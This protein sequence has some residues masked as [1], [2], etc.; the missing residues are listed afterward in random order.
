MKGALVSI[1][2]VW[3]SSVL[4]LAILLLVGASNARAGITVSSDGD[5]VNIQGSDDDDRVFIESYGFFEVKITDRADSGGGYED[6]SV[7]GSA[8]WCED[9]GT[10]AVCTVDGYID[11]GISMEV[12]LYGGETD[13]F[14]DR[15]TQELPTTVYGGDGRDNIWT[16]SGSSKD[17]I[18]AGAGTDYANTYGGKDTIYGDEDEDYLIGGKGSD[19]IVGGS[20]EDTI[21]GNQGD[22][23]IRTSG[24][25]YVD[26]VNCGNGTDSVVASDWD[27]TDTV[28]TD[29]EDVSHVS[30]SSYTGRESTGL[31]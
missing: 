28:N 21:Y 3:T 19:Y 30:S 31:E 24:E 26:E 9:K 18:Y 6:V 11:L 29:C 25:F 1:R 8:I 4:L 5:V 12:H 22:D 16:N 14:V 13:A 7:T 23:S 2:F 20:G 27:T 15:S 10:Y 17:V